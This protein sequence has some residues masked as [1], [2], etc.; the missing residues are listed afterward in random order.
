M[1]RFQSQT[2]REKEKSDGADVLFE[3]PNVL[4]GEKCGHT[5]F[6]LKAGVHTRQARSLNFRGSVVQS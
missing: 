6:K 1:I 3:N 2:K 5:K 4:R